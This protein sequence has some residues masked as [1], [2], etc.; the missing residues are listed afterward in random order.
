MVSTRSG[1][2][3]F[4]KPF[5]QQPL[6]SAAARRV[7]KTRIAR[8][9]IR[10]QRKLRARKLHQSILGRN[11]TF[12]GKVIISLPSEARE[13]DSVRLMNDDKN[14]ELGHT[15][16][17][18]ADGSYACSGSSAGYMGAAVAWLDGDRYSVESYE[19][20]RYTGNS[21][22]AEIFAIAAALGKAKNEVWESMDIHLVKVYS[23]AMGIL[24]AL[25][26]G[27]PCRV[28]PMLSNENTAIR[29]IYD[30]AK[31]LANKGVELELL[32][33][34]GHSESTGNALADRAAYDAV[35]DQAERLIPAAWQ[36]DSRPGKRMTGENVPE[37]W[38][39]MGSDWVEEWLSRANG[40]NT[41]DRIARPAFM[42]AS[43][44]DDLPTTGGLPYDDNEPSRGDQEPDRT[45]AEA[46]IHQLLTRNIHHSAKDQSRPI[47]HMTHLTGSLPDDLPKPDN[48]LPHDDR[49]EDE[50]SEDGRLDDDRLEDDLA[51]HD[52]ERELQQSPAIG[53]L[54]FSIPGLT[55]SVPNLNQYGNIAVEQAIQDLRTKLNFKNAHITFLEER[56]IDRDGRWRPGLARAALERLDME[57]DE[58]LS[59]L[60]VYEAKLRAR[61][62]DKMDKCP[63]VIEANSTPAA[64]TLVSAHHANEKS[65]D[66]DMCAPDA[67]SHPLLAVGDTFSS[68]QPNEEHGEVCKGTLVEETRS[69]FVAHAVSKLRLSSTP[70]GHSMFTSRLF[71]ETSDMEHKTTLVE[72]DNPFLPVC[73]LF[74]TRWTDEH[75]NKVDKSALVRKTSPTL[76]ARSLISSSSHWCDGDS[77]EE[78]T[79]YELDMQIENDMLL[80]QRYATC[81]L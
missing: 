7:D 63:P 78:G 53:R 60:Q 56:V 37:P 22:D 28:G 12:S 47:K 70:N 20:G 52:Q 69:C 50:R 71:T 68:H 59:S 73:S 39:H 5:S 8:I 46:D 10:A 67:E 13:P 58:I 54:A 32:W 35:S 40:Q 16:V 65:D 55:F 43:S 19:L 57:R 49:L 30:R 75:S 77:D 61:G 66:V 62:T 1:H 15:I 14:I 3:Y 76:V 34:K 81:K 31:W 44:D 25:A 72:N 48:G 2:D 21:E 6:A 38:K 74:T 17:Y 51:H 29:A 24:Q 79:Q 27:T 45:A 26:N 33:V 11:P 18:W 80:A 9:E 4:P 41:E 64:R 23:D 42:D 36:W